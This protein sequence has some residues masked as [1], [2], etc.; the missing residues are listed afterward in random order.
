MKM[1]VKPVLSLIVLTAATLAAAGCND[2]KLRSDAAVA[3][4][5]QAKVSAD[6]AVE[7]KQI[8]VQADKG[9][10][11]LSGVVATE[12][13][14]SAAAADAASVA[15]VRTV[16]NNLS[17]APAQPEPQAIAQPTPPEPAEY[18]PETRTR[19]RAEPSAKPA[20]ASVRQPRA[21]STQLSQR[22]AAQPRTVAVA[23]RPSDP[24]QGYE[25]QQSSQP[26]QRNDQQQDYDQQ[27]GYDQGYDQQEPANAPP[28]AAAQ[29]YPPSRAPR[30]MVTVPAGTSISIRMVDSLDSETAQAGDTFRATLNAPI[31]LG[32]NI[33]VPADSDV[34]G[35]VIEV[36][37]AGRFKGAAL[38][39]IELTRLRYN[40]QSY[41]ITTAPW[42]KEIAG[43]GK[44][45]AAKV[46]G[47]AALGAIIGGIAG[48]G[49]GA[50]IGTVVG[51]GAGATAQGVTKQKQI[52]LEPE[53]LLTFRLDQSV[54]VRPASVNE[55]A[56]GRERLE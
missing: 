49:K 21:A 7:N 44:G 20:A 14:R 43:R 13:E 6:Q 53:T 42:T 23:Q 38:L 41:A 24:Q 22:A 2:T 1:I 50:A 40:G 30:R 31:D 3:G 29:P 47:G 48:G 45:T 35:R 56:R 25:P 26:Q 51:G 28:P 52:T 33:V 19:S 46:G 8:G 37:S 18:A 11:T 27:Q 15:G 34:V 12:A 5:I 54:S 36:H 10:V 55:R 39:T 17:V 32:G 4:E 9:V 16:V